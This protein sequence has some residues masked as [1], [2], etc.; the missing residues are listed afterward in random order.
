MNEWLEIAIAIKNWLTLLGIITAGYFVLLAIVC[1]FDSEARRF[2]KS[3]AV[4]IRSDFAKLLL[5]V[6]YHEDA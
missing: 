5:K 2:V 6:L 3:V 4:K 1:V